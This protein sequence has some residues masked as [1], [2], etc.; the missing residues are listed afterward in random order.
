M[1]QT[2]EIEIIAPFEMFSFQHYSVHRVFHSFTTA[3]QGPADKLVP[4][5]QTMGDKFNLLLTK[6]RRI[7][8]QQCISLCNYF[9]S[10]NHW[11]VIWGIDIFYS[12]LHMVPRSVADQL[13]SWSL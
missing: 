4:S 6:V 5:M 3:Q 13:V 9:L 7:L 12:D 1:G 10:T 2:P 11:L 8:V